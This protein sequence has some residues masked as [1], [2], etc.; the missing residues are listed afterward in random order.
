MKPFLYTIFTLFIATLSRLESLDIPTDKSSSKYKYDLAICAIFRDE[1]PYLKE[2]I[3]FHKLLGVQH[4]YLYNNR[5]SDNFQE[6]L[7][8]YIFRNEVELIDWH[9]RHEDVSRWSPIQTSAYNDCINKVKTK[10]KWLAILDIDEFLFPV[11]SD[12]LVKFLKNYEDYAALGVNWQMFGTSNVSQ[13]SKGE[14]M[15]EK[16]CMKALADHEE[17]IHIKSIV[18]PK[19]VSSCENPHFCFLNEGQVQVNANKEIFTGPFSPYIT[20]DKIRI[21]HYWTRDEAFFNHIKIKRRMDWKEGMDGILNRKNK[22]SIVE[23]HEILRFAKKLRKKM[24]K[25]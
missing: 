19:H 17:N 20:I 13:I 7:K 6:V 3:E 8:P 16:L 25:D 22:L 24:F 15:I 1:A 23:D 14:L 2:W 11:Q 18:R 12:N 9:Y 10:V 21:N 4:F 5:S